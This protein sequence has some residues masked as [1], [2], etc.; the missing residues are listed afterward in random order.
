MGGFNV[1]EKFRISNLNESE[2]IIDIYEKYN[3]KIIQYEVVDD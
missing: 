1:A 3:I 2:K